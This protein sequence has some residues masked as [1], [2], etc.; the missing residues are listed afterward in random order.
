MRRTCGTRLRAKTLLT[1]YTTRSHTTRSHFWRAINRRLNF[2]PFSLSP[3]IYTS[4]H[5]SLSV[6]LSAEMQEVP[7]GRALLRVRVPRRHRR[8]GRLERARPDHSRRL[9]V[10]P[11]TATARTAAVAA[12][13]GADA[14]ARFNDTKGAR[15]ILRPGFLTL[16]VSREAYAAAADAGFEY[17]QLSTRLNLAKIIG[18]CRHSR[19]FLARCFLTRVMM[20]VCQV[21]AV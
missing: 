1:L 13:L 7:C 15:H 11:S 5:T 21:R 16:I 19:R 17:F 6:C 12:G 2:H 14:A 4:I 20:Y 3:Y 8:R 10:R 18:K 9:D